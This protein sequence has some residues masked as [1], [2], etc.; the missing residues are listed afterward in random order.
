MTEEA[1]ER[2]GDGGKQVVATAAGICEL[3]QT[4]QVL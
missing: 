1:G 4:D 3:L 2:R